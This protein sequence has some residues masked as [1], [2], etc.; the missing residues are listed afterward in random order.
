LNLIP[1]EFPILITDISIHF[2]LKSEY[3]VI[4]IYSD[5]QILYKNFQNRQSELFHQRMMPQ[6]ADNTAIRMTASQFWNDY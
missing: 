3:K 6:V 2:I 4:P 1:F 5:F